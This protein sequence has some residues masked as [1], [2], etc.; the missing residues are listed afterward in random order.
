MALDEWSRGRLALA[1]LF[2]FL[3]VSGLALIALALGENYV[4]LTQVLFVA[5]DGIAFAVLVFRPEWVKGLD[6]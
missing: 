3:F 1:G 5:F 4:P 6:L 2:G